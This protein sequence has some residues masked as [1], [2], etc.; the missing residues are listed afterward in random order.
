MEPGGSGAVSRPQVYGWSPTSTEICEQNG[1]VSGC[2]I[3]PGVLALTSSHPMRFSGM[4]NVPIPSA[5]NAAASAA[6][7]FCALVSE[8][9]YSP[10]P[11][12]VNHFP[13]L[14]WFRLTF[15]PA[16]CGLPKAAA[17]WSANWPLS[18]FWLIENTATSCTC[19]EPGI[20]VHADIASAILCCS[21]RRLGCVVYVERLQPPKLA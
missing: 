7:T 3:E 5:F 11:E 21:G 18:K 14:T 13:K 19:G 1:S 4:T 2:L 8:V 15:Q 6:A 20:C 10:T 12:I 9:V 17:I 16:P